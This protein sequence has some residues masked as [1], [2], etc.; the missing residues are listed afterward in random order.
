MDPPQLQISDLSWIA[1]FQE[2]TPNDQMMASKMSLRCAGL[3]RAANRTVKT[4]V[5]TDKDL[6]DPSSLDDIINQIN[7]YSLASKPAM[8]P[9][10][11]IPGEPSFPPLPN[12][13]SLS[14]NG[15]A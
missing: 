2:F 13:H 9:L 5:I 15:T 7:Y 6:D 4:L 1:I 14:A 10:M 8:R 3:V 11:D 12:D